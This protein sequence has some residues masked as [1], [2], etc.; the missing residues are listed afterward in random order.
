MSD[1]FVSI[2]CGGE[3]CGQCGK[4]AQHKVEETIFDDDPFQQRHPLTV[5]LCRF[6]FAQIMNRGFYRMHPQPPERSHER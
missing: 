6:H 2:Y 1:E 5:Y 3:R 4:P